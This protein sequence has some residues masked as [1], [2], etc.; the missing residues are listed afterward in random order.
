[1]SYVMLRG[2]GESTPSGWRA[3][4]H[5][6]GVPV[7]AQK[8]GITSQ[9]DAREL[10]EDPATAFPTFHSGM[11][12]LKMPEA[13]PTQPWVD[14][15]VSE[16]WGVIAT[17]EYDVVSEA[18]MV[19]PVVWS[20]DPLLVASL[21]QKSTVQW[22]WVDGPQALFAQIAKA[23][24]TMK[25][26]PTPCKFPGDPTFTEGDVLCGDKPPPTS[27]KPQIVFLHEDGVQVYKDRQLV[28]SMLDSMYF[29]EEQRAENTVIG[30]AVS[31]PSQAPPG[32][33]SGPWV[34]ARVAE[35]LAVMAL[36]E[37]LA[38]P[39]GTPVRVDMTD[40]YGIV[41]E[42]I[43]VGQQLAWVDGPPELL[44]AAKRH[45][46]T[47]GK[48]PVPPMPRPVKPAVAA[49]GSGNDWIAPAAL[50]GGLLLVVAGIAKR[51]Q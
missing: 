28:T 25:P 30:L 45:L 42:L 10:A 20:T 51:K 5:V 11:A 48:P 15:L 12:S 31:D 3:I 23:L 1:M 4:T 7:F 29:V 13:P 27:E 50:F 14:G 35:G 40:D 44:A 32:V 49:S 43:R 36:P 41:A 21:L 37:G 6:D 33:P 38:A 39:P 24:G 19:I 34:K 17:T 18:N 26:M 46:A 8:A 9:L 22:A 16:G 47:G 2:F